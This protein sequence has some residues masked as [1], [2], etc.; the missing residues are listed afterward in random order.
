[1]NLTE[2]SKITGRSKRTLSRWIKAGKLKA[3]CIGTGYDINKN[4]IVHLCQVDNLDLVHSTMSTEVTCQVDKVTN[5]FKSLIIRH[6]EACVYIGQLEAR[7]RQIESDKITLEGQI[8]LL[9]APDEFN[10]VKCERDIFKKD[11][12]LLQQQLQQTQEELTL[13]KT[14]W[15]KKIFMRLQTAKAT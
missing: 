12:E 1:M 9:P 15:Y 5:D 10:R 3:K 8:K 2:V 6:E 14:P 13:L 11:N 4:D 7:N